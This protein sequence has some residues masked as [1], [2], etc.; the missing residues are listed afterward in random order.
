MTTT[1]IV[2]TSPAPLGSDKLGR[3]P[4]I[5]WRAVAPSMRKPLCR[6]ALRPSCG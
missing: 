6:C 1:R 5:R 3:P 2:R 4:S